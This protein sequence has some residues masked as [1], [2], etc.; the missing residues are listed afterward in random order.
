MAEAA[1]Q[2]GDDGGTAQSQDV[3][4]ASAAESAAAAA[5]E[6]DTR[7]VEAMRAQWRRRR[8]GVA[9]VHEESSHS[10]TSTELE[11][12]IEDSMAPQAPPAAKVAGLPEEESDSQRTKRRRRYE[13]PT[14]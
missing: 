14:A 8:P 9:E 12:D 2:A 4:D 6:E 5:E 7:A 11:T 10:D 13:L 3:G 1:G